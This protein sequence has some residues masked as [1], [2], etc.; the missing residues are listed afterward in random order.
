MNELGESSSGEKGTDGAISSSGRVVQS[1][2]Q[3]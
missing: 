2:G 1:D 3:Y